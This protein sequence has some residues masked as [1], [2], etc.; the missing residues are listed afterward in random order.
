MSA[1]ASARRARR[2]SSAA[3]R[4]RPRFCGHLPWGGAADTDVGGR[5]WSAHATR[6]AR[7]APFC[8]L[9]PVSRLALFFFFFSI[10]PSP[11]TASASPL[12]STLLRSAPAPPVADP[13]GVA[14]PAASPALLCSPA[15]LHYPLAA[16]AAPAPPHPAA[17]ASPRIASRR[18]EASSSRA[19]TRRPPPSPALLCRCCCC[20]C[21]CRLSCQG[22]QQKC[23]PSRH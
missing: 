12:A 21:C 5:H 22:Q 14:A 8:L 7:F 11:G 20:C 10:A 17:L 19:A 1:P 16:E 9:P 3:T 4:R 6:F 18:A 13:I 2:P 15:A 23:P